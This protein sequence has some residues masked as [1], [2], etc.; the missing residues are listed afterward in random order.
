M[1]YAKK[2]LCMSRDTAFLSLFSGEDMTVPDRVSPRTMFVSQEKS[3]L[4]IIVTVLLCRSRG[5]RHA[6]V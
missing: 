1:D 2:I 4:Y 6:G 3:R 5:E